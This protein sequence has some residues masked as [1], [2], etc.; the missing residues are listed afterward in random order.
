[1]WVRRPYVRGAGKAVA[2]VAVG[3]IEVMDILEFGERDS[4]GRGAAHGSSLGGK[5][6]PAVLR[7]AAFPPDVKVRGATV[8]DIAAVT[9]LVRAAEEHDH[10]VAD[11]TLE[12]V[13]SDWQRPGFEPAV[14]AVLVEEA[15]R[16]AGYAEVPGWRAH[17]T[18][19]PA[20]R[21]RG[22]GTAL[23]AWIEERASQRSDL[24]REVRVGQTIADT[25]ETAAA[26][27]RKHGYE[28]RHTS[29]VLYLPEDVTIDHRP[30]PDGIVI[31]PFEPY[32]EE[33][34]VY[35]VIEDA[36]NEWPTRQPTSFED[37]R[38]TTTQR[39][40]FDPSLLL[41]AA[42]ADTVVGAAFAIAYPDEGSVERLAVC[43]DH[44]GRGVA[45]A[46][47]KESFAEFRRRG[48]PAMGL[49]TDSRTG[50]LDLYLDLGMVVRATYT[51]YSKLL[52][53][54]SK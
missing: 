33:R 26:L 13:E 17:A 28:P 19:H 36:F 39:A 15:D 7:D 40:D 41:V 44:R 9:S 11:M 4:S 45:K 38:A 51:H 43:R 27:F 16:L 10:G 3:S 1:M 14:D 29:W 6:Q 49:S 2:W 47:L 21:G 50:A 54:R 53:L 46:L 18:V 25:N 24:G 31:R 12:D 35:Q 30:L 23:L 42:T 22:I 20:S 37:W 32:T 5:V 8:A 48:L 34:L 52:T